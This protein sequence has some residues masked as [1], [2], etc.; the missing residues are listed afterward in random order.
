MKDLDMSNVIKFPTKDV[1]AWKKIENWIRE[2]CKEA[3][4]SD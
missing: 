2:T 4:L 1:Q 3:G